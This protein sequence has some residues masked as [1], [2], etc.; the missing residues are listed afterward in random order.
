MKE[1]WLADSVVQNGQLRP[2]TVTLAEVVAEIV[3]GQMS[4]GP[5]AETPGLNHRA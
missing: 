4:V 2:D 3:R 5:K 1:D